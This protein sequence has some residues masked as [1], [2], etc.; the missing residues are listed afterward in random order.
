MQL[1]VDGFRA[2][3][4]G[5]GEVVD[6]FLLLQVLYDDGIV[7]VEQ[8]E[9]AKEPFSRAGWTITDSLRFMWIWRRR[10]CNAANAFVRH[11]TAVGV[12][13]G[14]ADSGFAT[15]MSVQAGTNRLWYF[16]GYSILYAPVDPL[17]DVAWLRYE[18]ELTDTRWQ[19][20][21]SNLQRHRRQ[22]IDEI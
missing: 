7:P 11:C 6:G 20:K 9:K 5:K 13:C 4:K 3:L 8:D 14:S 15:L 18:W 21:W 10:I 17:P 16:H 2:A 22:D 12:L 1:T 19:R